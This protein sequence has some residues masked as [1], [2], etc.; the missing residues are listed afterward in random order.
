MAPLRGWPVKRWTLEARQDALVLTWQDTRL[1]LTGEE[2]RRLT[3]RSGWFSASL[4]VAKGEP[5]KLRGLPKRNAREVEAAVARMLA[6]HR[7]LPAVRAAA[8]WH[9]QVLGTVRQAQTMGRWISQESRAVMAADR[10]G[11]GVR[12]AL[13]AVRSDLDSLFSGDDLAAARFLLDLDLDTWLDSCNEEILQSETQ[14]HRAFFDSVDSRPLTPEQIRAVVCFDNRVQVVASAGSGKTSVMV[15][16]AAYAVMRGFAPPEGVLL[17][18]FNKAAAEELQERVERGLARAK[19]PTAGVKATTFH[20][21]GLSVL[22][23]ATGRKPRAA[24][25][26]DAGQDVEMV[27]RIVDELR[28]ASAAFAYRWD[29]FRLLYA[30][31]SESVEGGEPDGWDSA[32][33]RQGFRTANGEVVKS[34]GERTIANFLFYNGVE[35]SYE[36]PYCH[37]VADEDHSQYRPDFHYVTPDGE[38][39]HE[40]WGVS[41]ARPPFPGY[42]ESMQWKRD[43]HAERGTALLETTWAQIM[44]LSGLE[45]FAEQL[46]M[47][48]LELDWNPDRP[49]PG[50]KPLKHEDLARLMR[51]FMSHVKSKAA[52]QT[53]NVSRA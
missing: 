44:S 13:T 49:A 38:L 48:G 19:L 31:A 16:R 50:S 30:R 42:L 35:Y 41:P 21:F 29:L 47:H 20:A 33:R 52:A 17:L 27:T 8:Q 25:W 23:K 39:W 28:D 2:V 51:S 3:V 5:P 46:R 11:P 6:R 37:D 7:A 9:K 34:E 14:R 24:A 43:L 12:T 40:H 53:F 4:L 36:R 1:V 10:P 15:A 45:E 32:N 26:L 18:A 22:G